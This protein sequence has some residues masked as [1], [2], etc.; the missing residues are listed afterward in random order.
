L[1]GGMNVGA[2]YSFNQDFAHLKSRLVF[3]PGQGLSIPKEHSTW[4]AYWSGW[5][6]LYVEEPREQPIDLLNGMA[7]EQGVGRFASFGFA[8]KNT[9]PVEWSVSGGVGGR[10][11]IPSRDDDTFGIGYYYAKLETLRFSE[12]L[13]LRD[14]TQGFECFYNIA[15]TPACHLTMD[16]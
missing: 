13:A 10:G 6:Y 7:A 5:Q 9:N 4:A 3:E 2:L 11:V 8:D 14:S 16:V 15:V 1:P 12:P